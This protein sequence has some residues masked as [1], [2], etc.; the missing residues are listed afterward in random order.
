MLGIQ[1]ACFAFSMYESNILPLEFQFHGLV[2]EETSY[3]LFFIL[4]D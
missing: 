3:S 2:I 4:R 1:L